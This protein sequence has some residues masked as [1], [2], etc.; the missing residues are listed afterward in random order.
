MKVAAALPVNPLR[1]LFARLDLRNHRKIA[2]M[3]GRTAYVGSQNITDSS[4]GYRPLRKIGPWIDATAR[5]EGPAAQALEVVFLRDWEIESD[6]RLGDQL[7]ELLPEVP[8]PEGGSIVHVVPSGPG[9]GLVALRQAVVTAI[10][11][12]RE[13][14]IMTTPYFVP[15]DSTKDALIAAALRGVAVTVVMPK[16]VDGPLTGAAARSHYRDMLEAGVRIKHFRSGLLHAKTVTVDSDMAMIGSANLDMRSFTLNFE[17]T[18]FVYDT[19]EA[20]L[21]RMLQVS[22]MEDSDDVF[23][24]EWAARPAWKRLVDNTARLLGPLL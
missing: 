8:V 13:E 15:D 6:E 12:A 2:V 7:A 11:S 20:S 14:L 16:R 18:L 4:F 5:V 19:D 24:E 10:F 9:D 3:D 23:L 1:M 17:V 22:Y 21:L